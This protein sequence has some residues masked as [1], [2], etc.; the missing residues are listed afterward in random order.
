MS[1]PRRRRRRRRRT[2]QSGEQSRSGSSQ[3][4]QQ[5]QQQQASSGRSRRRRGRRRGA[6]GERKPTSPRLSEDLVRALPGEK[7]TQLTGT[8]DGTTMEQVIGEL[9]SEWGV[10]QYPQEYRITIKVAEERDA[11]QEP[12]ASMEQPQR[13][14]AEAG[15]AAAISTGDGPKREKAPAPPLMSRLST[16]GTG[17]SGKRKRRRRG[18]RRGGGGGGGGGP[19]QPAS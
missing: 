18:R 8:S 3:P 11:R 5:P 15:Q 6:A 4:Q 2:G 19:A 14:R 10:P 12:A 13:E 9:Q 17:A 7:P 1:Q 16:G